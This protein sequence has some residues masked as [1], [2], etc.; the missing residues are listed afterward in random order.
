LF[1][2]KAKEREKKTESTTLRA[3]GAGRVQVKPDVREDV[4]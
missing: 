3:G 2:P 1:S 4:V